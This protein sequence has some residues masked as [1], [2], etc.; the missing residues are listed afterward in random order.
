MYIYCTV[1]EKPNLTDTELIPLLAKDIENNKLASIFKI[2]EKIIKRQP[3]GSYTVHDQ[4]IHFVG[5]VKV[6]IKGAKWIWENEMLHI[7]TADKIEH[8]INKQNVL[9]VQRRVE[10][11]KGVK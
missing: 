1:R 11:G 2:M 8:I 6:T 7:V 10:Y 4:I 5:G 9:F 3:D